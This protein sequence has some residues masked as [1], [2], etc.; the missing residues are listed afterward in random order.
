VVLAGAAGVTGIALPIEHGLAAPEKRL[1]LAVAASF[2]LH[3]AVASLVPP[4][5][6][7]VPPVA[8]TLEVL[9]LP[10]PEAPPAIAEPAPVAKA[11]PTAPRPRPAAPRPSPI[12]SLS[13]EPS[14]DAAPAPSREPLPV[15]DAEA[16]ARSGPAP[17][18]PTATP[19]APPV[20]V[21]VSPDLLAGYGSSISRL[22]ARHREYPRVAAQRG[23]EGTVTMRLRV[24]PGG[25]LVDARVDGSSGHAVLDAQALAMVNRL[26]DLPPPP[27]SLREREFAVLVPVVFQL[28]R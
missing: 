25:R 16:P 14:R 17:T 23:W 11:P 3:A 18:A 10:S 27:D 9:V 12:P 13:P 6:T 19:E 28:E 8:R 15:A 1:A 20:A 5:E 24:A 4:V 21:A 22:L 2:A 26:G 7:S